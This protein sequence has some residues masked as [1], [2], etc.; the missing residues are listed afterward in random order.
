[1]E[2]FEIFLKSG[3]AL[4]Q[5]LHELNTLL[6]KPTAGLIGSSQ[7]S[8]FIDMEDTTTK[9]HFV[10]ELQTTLQDK[11]DYQRKHQTLMEYR[12]L[13]DW[14]TLYP[15]DTYVNMLQAHLAVSAN[16]SLEA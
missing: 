14:K 1:L 15:F 12:H 16:A 7:F 11:H 10:E 6:V 4:Q 5:S 3:T 13:F 2:I 9:H 8:Y